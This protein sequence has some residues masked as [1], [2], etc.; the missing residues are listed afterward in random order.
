MR[1]VIMLLLFASIVGAFSVDTVSDFPAQKHGGETYSAFYRVNG[2]AVY[3]IYGLINVSE[4]MIVDNCARY[5]VWLCNITNQNFNITIRLPV[6]I[7]PGN[8]NVTVIFAANYTVTD[9]PP[10]PQYRSNSGSGGGSSIGYSKPTNNKTEDAFIAEMN[11]E[12]ERL[13][14]ETDAILNNPVK[15]QTNETE[16]DRKNE[17]T[18]LLP[19]VTPVEVVP[20][21]AALT[22][23]GLRID[24]GLLVLLGVIGV[25]GLI[26]FITAIF[27]YSRINQPPR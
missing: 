3:P 4:D 1:N 20:L 9:T 21:A 14:N 2:D 18:A 5:D 26:V 7:S 8:Y 15:E 27:V 23:E 13:R 19:T 11:K 22:N 16:I 17:P 24:E 10:P 25:G 6:N 12:I